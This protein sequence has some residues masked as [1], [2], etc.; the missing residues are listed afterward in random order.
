MKCVIIIDMQKDF[1]TG[2]AQYILSRKE[3]KIQ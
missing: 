2:E 3:V 1:V